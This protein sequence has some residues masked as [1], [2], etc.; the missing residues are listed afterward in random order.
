[1]VKKK[2]KEFNSTYTL[3]YKTYKD[4]S[5]G[6][7]AT[8]RSNI[9]ILF[10]IVVVL[11]LNIIFKHYES[12]ILFCLVF[13]ILTLIYKII[14]RD[15]NTYRRSKSLNNGEEVEVNV[16][17]DSEKIT[18]TSTNNVSSYDFNQ[19]IGIVENNNLLIL[20]LKY[21]MGIILNKDTLTGGTKEE[22]VDYLLL[23][24]KNIKKKK[25]I[26]AHMGIV[27]RKIILIVFMVLFIL[28]IV[29]LTI[30]QGEVNK[31]IRL[32][33]D[34]G[35]S[36]E[37]DEDLYNGHNTKRL[38]ITKVGEESWPLMYAFGTE[39]DAIRNIQYWANIETNNDIKEEYIIEDSQD[40][41]KYVINNS[42]EYIVLIR[43]DNFVFYGIANIG[44]EE[45]LN[46]VV[47][48]I[49]EEMR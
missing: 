14:G 27:L 9:I 16:T 49:D 28:S 46:E 40:Y 25:V 47:S 11:I 42:D 41:Q 34:N 23:M 12:V 19:V 6:Y 4:F 26:N 22:L 17:I 39:K 18:L 10:L 30:R 38:T 15:K 36:V 37:V 44:Y 7:L 20:K 45:E 31:Y 33:E 24:C 43:K 1:M 35:Y 3:S 8:K 2:K 5:N 21:N 48:I 32:L 13:I 29:L